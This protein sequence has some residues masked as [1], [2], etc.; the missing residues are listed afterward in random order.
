MLNL[1]YRISSGYSIDNL[2][3]G[4]PCLAYAALKASL[5]SSVLSCGTI[6]QLQPILAFGFI[7]E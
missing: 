4:K 3:M 6:R 5:A 7:V 2:G 1:V